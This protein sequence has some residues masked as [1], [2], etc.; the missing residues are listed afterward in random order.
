MPEWMGQ[1]LNIGRQWKLGMAGTVVTGV[2]IDLHHQQSSPRLAHDIS[3]KGSGEGDLNCS[4][5]WSAAIRFIRK[6]IERLS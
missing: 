6:E 3:S 5:A 2:T 1:H 4:A